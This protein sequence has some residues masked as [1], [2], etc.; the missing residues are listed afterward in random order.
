M[1]GRGTRSQNRSRLVNGCSSR[2]WLWSNELLG[3][4][5]FCSLKSTLPLQRLAGS[6]SSSLYKRAWHPSN[7]PLLALDQWAHSSLI[8]LT[9]LVVAYIFARIPNHTVTPS[10]TILE[11]GR[12]KL[13]KY[14]LLTSKQSNSLT[15]CR[16]PLT[17]QIAAPFAANG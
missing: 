8:S 13:Y 6:R 11:H 7:N 12:P 14:E 4:I 17:K 5:T 3:H 10:L 16:S 9:W 15:L 1:F 2:Y